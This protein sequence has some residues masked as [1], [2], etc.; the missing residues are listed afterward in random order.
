MV[1]GSANQ[2]DYLQLYF[3]LPVSK[4]RQFSGIVALSVNF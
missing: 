1:L 4:N 3:V 2:L